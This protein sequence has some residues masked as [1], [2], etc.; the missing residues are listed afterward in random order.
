MSDELSLPLLQPLTGLWHLALLLSLISLTILGT[1]LMST[2]LVAQA[3]LRLCTRKTFTYGRKDKNRFLRLPSNGSCL[4]FLLIASSSQI[5]QV[6][7]WESRGRVAWLD[8]GYEAAQTCSYICGW[9]LALYVLLS[10]IRTIPLFHARNAPDANPPKCLWTPIVHPILVDVL[11]FAVP[12]LLCA[13]PGLG[14]MFEANSVLGSLNALVGEAHSSSAVEDTIVTTL[15][16]SLKAALRQ[17][18]IQGFNRALGHLL[19]LLLSILVEFRAYLRLGKIAKYLSDSALQSQALAECEK[20]RRMERMPS[21]PPSTQLSKSYTSH[22]ETTKYSLKSPRGHMHFLPDLEFHLPSPSLMTDENSYDPAFDFSASQA[23]ESRQYGRSPSRA[24]SCLS[25]FTETFSKDEDTQGCY[26]DS[27]DH[28]QYRPAAPMRSLSRG[29]FL[30]PDMV[31]SRSHASSAPSFQSSYHSRFSSASH[32]NSSSSCSCTRSVSSSLKALHLRTFQPKKSYH[33]P[34]SDEILQQRRTRL[35]DSGLFATVL[36]LAMF[37]ETS[38][39]G[40][41]SYILDQRSLQAVFE[42]SRMMLQIVPFLGGLLLA[43]CRSMEDAYGWETDCPSYDE[44]SNASRPEW[45]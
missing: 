26:Q 43:A 10:G 23:V 2:R 12:I 1:L 34:T 22:S 42:I 13:T 36:V 30:L 39:A 14:L 32:S 5:V 4:L 37:F 31:R 8:F 17:W 40:L 21:R 45:A 24:A 16:N 29:T 7:K 35:F 41:A 18:R 9:L 38:Y 11:F 27:A 33:G 19:L 6:L 28:T 20:D 25:G 44:Q 3:N 15:R